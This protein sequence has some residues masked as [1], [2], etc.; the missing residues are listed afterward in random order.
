MNP[1][2]RDSA[3]AEGFGYSERPLVLS[4]N[5][6]VANNGGF[7]YP[8]YEQY[9]SGATLQTAR[10]SLPHGILMY[11]MQGSTNL[12]CFGIEILSLESMAAQGILNS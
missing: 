5:L 2:L 9:I 10:K 8:T 11:R 3:K 12:A 4:F 1:R 6:S 7:V